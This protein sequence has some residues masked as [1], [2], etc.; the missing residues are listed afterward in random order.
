MPFSQRWLWSF[1]L[2]LSVGC[3]STATG[4]RALLDIARSE[5]AEPASTDDDEV[6]SIKT[7]SLSED[8]KVAKWSDDP[9]LVEVVNR[10]LADAS[11]ERRQQWIERIASINPDEIPQ[12]LAERRRLIQAGEVDVD[13]NLPDRAVSTTP[14]ESLIGHDRKR[15]RTHKIRGVDAPLQ[16]PSPSTANSDEVLQQTAMIDENSYGTESSE[17]DVGF[18]NTVFDVFG[19]SGDR[20]AAP[21]AHQETTEIRPAG[22]DQ[23]KTKTSKRE[24]ESDAKSSKTDSSRSLQSV[25]WQEELD[26]LVA[27][28]ETQLAHQELGESQLE[29]DLYLRQHVAL[30]LLYLIGSRRPEALQSIPH[31][32]PNQQEFWTEMMWA[33]SNVFDD[34]AL[35][36]PSDRARETLERLR[37][38]IDHLEPLAGLDV[39]HTVFCRQIDGFGNYT[40]FDKDEF[41]P[42]ESVLIYTEVENFSTLV[43]TQGDYVTKLQSTLDIHEESTEGRV[44]FHNELAPT[45]DLCRSRRHDYFHSYR[46]KLPTNLTPGPHV[47]TLSIHD[48][49]GHKFGTASLHFVVR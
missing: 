3:Q 29:Q 12:L 19:V 30:K 9:V 28:L 31:D 14:S 44:V 13:Q 1:I 17:Q 45:E 10:E 20:Q 16:A 6:S 24:S 15:E 37:A 34:E 47:L 33:L 2:L 32:D 41:L 48:E 39:N 42:G 27:L 4:S 22:H 7:A 26:K 18:I 38:A 5:N 36:D 8:D 43:T 35:P 40:L 25:Y 49:V 21:D 11:P 46:V 23:G